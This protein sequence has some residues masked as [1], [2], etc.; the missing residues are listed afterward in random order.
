MKINFKYSQTRNNVIR[1]ALRNGADSSVTLQISGLVIPQ[2]AERDFASL[3][4]CE[5]DESTVRAAR[6]GIVDLVA[7]RWG[8]C[9]PAWG[10]N[11]SISTSSGTLKGSTSS[12][13][14][15]TVDENTGDVVIHGFRPETYE[16]AYNAIGQ[17]TGYNI[18]WADGDREIESVESTLGNF[19]TM[20]EYVEA[21]RKAGLSAP[22]PVDVEVLPATA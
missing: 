3:D 16:G 10:R 5:G 18:E 17:G 12:T 13:H 21:R 11:V 14:N 7:S 15:I 6:K 20:E 9:Q 22:E 4:V 1:F 2:V 8:L 19:R